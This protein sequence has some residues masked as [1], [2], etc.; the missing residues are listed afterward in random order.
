MFLKFLHCH[1]FIVRFKQKPQKIKESKKSCDISVSLFLCLVTFL[2]LL[3]NNILFIFL[4][5]SFHKF[6]N[7]CK[8]EYENK[9]N[10]LCKKK[11]EK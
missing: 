1:Y 5:K 2:L 11:N 10:N 4:P 6:F 8:M 3:S 7:N 9:T